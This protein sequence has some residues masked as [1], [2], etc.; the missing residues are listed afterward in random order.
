MLP[1][2]FVFPQR[3]KRSSH[4]LQLLLNSQPKNGAFVSQQFVSQA[5]ST[6]RRPQDATLP[7]TISSFQNF[8]CRTERILAQMPLFKQRSWLAL[9]ACCLAGTWCSTLLA[10]T[11][12]EA[13]RFPGG[14][15]TTAQRAA[16]REAEDDDSI[17]TSPGRANLGNRAKSAGQGAAGSKSAAPAGRAVVQPALPQ[18]PAAEAMRIPKVSPEMEAILEEWE[19]KSSKVKRLEGEFERTTYDYVFEV[20]KVSTGKYCF[21]FP[22]KG[23]FH[24]TGTPVSPKSTGRKKS[25]TTGKPF[26]LKSGPNERWICDGLKIFKFDDDKNENNEKVYNEIDI[27]EEDRGQNIRNAPLP[28]VFGMKAADAKQR[29]EFILDK[30]NTNDH[31]I[32]VKVRPLLPQDI[33]N[34]KEAEVILDRATCLPSAVKLTDPTGN[35]QDVYYFP[36]DKLV[37]NSKGWVRWLVGDPLKPDFRG[38]KKAVNRQDGVQMAPLPTDRRTTAT[39]AMGPK[40]LSPKAQPR[41]TAELPADDE[42][43]PPRKTT[44]TRP[45]ID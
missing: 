44:K 9:C 12:A 11:Q 5:V 37:V 20:E 45:K 38:Y 41:Q 31:Q 22:D 6:H 30:K 8:I 25:A 34:Y 4:N 27:P 15:Q 39:P 18:R 19:E 1:I 14:Q 17:P 42:T 24:Q 10:Q 40:P 28:F 26:S 2:R 13:R 36:K 29:Y 3:Q 43:P 7:V 35:T 21:Q 32:R 23:S 33:A 16:P